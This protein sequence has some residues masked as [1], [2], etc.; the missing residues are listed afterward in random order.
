MRSC[1][2]YAGRCSRPHSPC[3][4][5]CGRNAHRCSRCRMPCTSLIREHIL[6]SKTTLSQTHSL[7]QESC[8]MPCTPPPPCH[9]GKCQ[10]L[11][12]SSSFPPPLL[13]PPPLPS[14]LRRHLC[15]V[16]ASLP[17]F[18]SIPFFSCVFSLRVLHPGLFLICVY[19][20]SYTCS[21]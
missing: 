12:A 15:N 10:R 8:R 19:S 7:Q 17:P 20:S 9:L 3:T 5:S 2:G 1:G 18:C 14:S 13:P 16:G 6:Y 4:S 21:S 11:L